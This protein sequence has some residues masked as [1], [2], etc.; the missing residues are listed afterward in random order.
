MPLFWTGTIHKVVATRIMQRRWNIFSF[1]E[2]VTKSILIKVPKRNWTNR[3]SMCVCVCIY[4]NVCVYIYIYIYVYVCVCVYKERQREKKKEIE[5]YF[6]ELAHVI[7]QAGSS[8]IYTIDCQA[9]ASWEN[10][11]TAQIWKL[12][13]TISFCTRE[14]QIFVLFRFSTDWTKSTQIT[15]GNMPYSKSTH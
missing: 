4:M 3:I 1:F 9:G 7:G 8:K 12:F 2:E 11:D 15:E 5:I 14:G 13:T 6:K 10:N